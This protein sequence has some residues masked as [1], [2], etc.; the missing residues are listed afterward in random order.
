MNSKKCP[1]CSEIEYEKCCQTYHEGTNPP[2]ALAL[3][4]SRYS[5]YALQKTGYI[6]QTTHP[7][8]PYFEKDQKKWE[9]AILVF[10]KTTEFQKLEILEVHEDSVHFAAH[11]KQQGQQLILDE[12]SHF[13]KLEG[14]WL[15]VQG[16][17]KTQLI[18][19]NKIHPPQN[20]G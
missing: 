11:L 19:R 15:Y 14:K 3:M 5:A 7:D 2:T 18:T 17:A 9:R 20:L 6:L 12:K 10:C 4:R 8:S 13:Q 1:C 16:E